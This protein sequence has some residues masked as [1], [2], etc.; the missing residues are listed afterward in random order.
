[1]NR[2]IFIIILLLF[3]RFLPGSSLSNDED[4]LFYDSFGYYKKGK[5]HLT[6]HA[7]IYQKAEKSAWRNLLISSLKKFITAK[8]SNDIFKTRIKSF[9]Y[10]NKGKKIINIILND[11]NYSLNF[12]AADGHTIT[13]IVQDSSRYPA[14]KPNVL[15]FRSQ[16]S[17]QNSNQYT[18]KI[19]IISN[20]GISVISD[21]DDT[22]KDSKVTDK[23]QLL[24]STFEKEFLPVAGMPHVLNMF[25][26]K[27]AV[28]HYVS[29][30][31]WQLYRPLSEFIEKYYPPGILHLKKFRIKDSSIIDFIFQNQEDYKF[32]EIA[33]IIDTFANRNFVLLGDTGEKDA[34]TY[35]KIAAAYPNK[36]AAVYLRLVNK[37]RNAEEIRKLYANSKSV[38]LFLFQDPA[39]LLGGK[40]K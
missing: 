32:N 21:I 28:Y 7:N 9:L 5:I 38:Q 6:I 22:I 26:N 1:M 15:Y 35:A 16:P 13:E 8:D 3:F 25:K 18:G 27:G 2:N 14:S 24:K 17:Q 30:S 11:E 23:K 20:K 34:E 33:K 29:G 39:E 37:N 31:P 19:R 40:T 4:V 12:T 36:I 10:D